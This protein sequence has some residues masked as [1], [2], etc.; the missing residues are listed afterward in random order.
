MFVGGVNKEFKRQKGKVEIV[1]GWMILAVLIVL[2]GIVFLFTKKKKQIETGFSVNFITS[3]IGLVVGAF[4]TLPG[5][6]I[7][8]VTGK[9]HNDST[10]ELITGFVLIGI[11]IWMFLYIRNKLSILNLLGVKE[12]R[13]E[14]HRKDVRLKQFEFKERE[15]DLS[16]YARKMNQER[17]DEAAEMIKLK[18][19][20]FYSENKDVKKGYTGTAPIPLTMYAGL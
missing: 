10:L 14:E 20:S 9:G 4:G 5:K 13:I 2:F 18:M 17:F 3:G 19:Q 15:I 8:L 6:L 16:L 1:L 7:S 12:R 11:G